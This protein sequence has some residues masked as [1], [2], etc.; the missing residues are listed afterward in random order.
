MLTIDVGEETR[1]LVAGIAER[2]QPSQLVGRRIIVLANLQPRKLRGVESKGMLL[3][4]S[5][6]N[7]ELA[8]VGVDGAPPPGAKVS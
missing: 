1:T 6:G 8:I 5:W 2:Y 4:A 3:A 7:G